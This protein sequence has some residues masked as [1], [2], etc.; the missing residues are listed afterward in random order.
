MSLV[1]KGV[2][3]LV[4][5]VGVVRLIEVTTAAEGRVSDLQEFLVFE[6]ASLFQPEIR[7]QM[8]NNHRHRGP[9]KWGEGGGYMIFLKSN[10]PSDKKILFQLV[11]FGL[12]GCHALNC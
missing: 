11:N 12:R 2:V 5:V 4:V 3:S 6:V 7:N 9:L 1:V 8:R 10:A